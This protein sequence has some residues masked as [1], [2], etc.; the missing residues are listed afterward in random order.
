M[1]IKTELL[2]PL[3]DIIKD[4]YVNTVLSITNRTI[5]QGF[6]AINSKN[7]LMSDL[8]NHVIQTISS[9]KKYT[10][11]VFTREF[12]NNLLR[13]TEKELINGINY[14]KN[15]NNY[16][17]LQEK[18]SDIS[19]KECYDGF[20]RYGRCCNIYEADKKVIKTRYSDF[21]W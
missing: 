11:H 21:P 3:N 17:L 5:Y 1:D 6:V 4:N 12:Y 15:N 19:S 10:Y 8:I 14:G 2:A 18:C 9:G 13:D 20:D 16:Y 7:K